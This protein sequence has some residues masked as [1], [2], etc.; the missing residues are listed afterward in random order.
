MTRPRCFLEKLSCRAAAV[1]GPGAADLGPP[2]A[3][4]FPP[5]CPAAPSFSEACGLVRS[6]A[7]CLLLGPHRRHVALA[8]RYLRR[9]RSGIRQQLDAQLLRYSHSLQGVPVAYDNIKIVGPLGDIYDDQG[10]IHINIEAEF[11]IFSPEKGATLVGQVNK[12]SPSHIGCLVHGCF[13]ASIPKPEQMQSEQWKDLG[14]QIGDEL[15]FEVFRL[16]SDAAGVFCIRGQ[17][18]ENSL[19]AKCPESQ[20]PEESA[21][22]D[23]DPGATEETPKKKRKKKKDSKNHEEGDGAAEAADSATVAVKEETDIQPIDG[24]NGL[25]ET[26]LKKKKKKRKREEREAQ[27]PGF[28]G[29]DSSGYQSDHKKSKK[30]KRKHCDADSSQLLEEP[31]RKKNSE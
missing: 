28:H 20:A 13:N 24:V 6:R 30:K 29:S 2:G 14:I 12:V 31:L 1:G 10:H 17:L 7:S 26:P 15:E 21:E 3:P 8:P 16:D 25:C 27:D 5:R 22:I 9:K 23:H 11:V 18:N 4:G 19:K